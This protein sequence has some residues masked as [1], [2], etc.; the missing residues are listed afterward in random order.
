MAHVSV[1]LSTATSVGLRDRHRVHEKVPVSKTTCD[2]GVFPA[3]PRKVS[4]VMTLCLYTKSYL[5]HARRDVLLLFRSK[6]VSSID[7]ERALRCVSSTHVFYLY[8]LGHAVCTPWVPKRRK[9]CRSVLSHVNHPVGATSTICSA[10]SC[11]TKYN[12]PLLDHCVKQ[13]AF[14]NIHGAWLP[15]SAS[16]YSSLGYVM[17]RILNTRKH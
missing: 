4:S 17:A 1:H 9:G 2:P 13:Q 6:V 12:R 10:F 3:I 11:N 16:W 15:V 5:R 7:V 14:G 8:L